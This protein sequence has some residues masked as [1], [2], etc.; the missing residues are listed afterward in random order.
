MRKGGRAGFT[1]VELMVAVCILAIGL[2]GIAR[3]LLNAVSA[4]DYCNNMVNKMSFLDNAMCELEK[5]TEAKEGFE[6]EDQDI[7]NF[8]EEKNNEASDIGIG[9]LYWTT[10]TQGVNNEITEFEFKLVWQKGD[11]EKS[12]ALMCYLPSLVKKLPQVQ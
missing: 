8:L 3:S 5:I 12:E 10:L 2:V 6:S 7:T 4:L 1:L 11:N 9:R